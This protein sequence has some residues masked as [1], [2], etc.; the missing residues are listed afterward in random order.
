MNEAEQLEKRLGEI[1]T[2]I[3]RLEEALSSPAWELLVNYADEQIRMRDQGVVQ[4]ALSLE[5]VLRQNNLKSEAAGMRLLISLIPNHL[6][7]LRSQRKTWQIHQE[8]LNGRRDEP[9]PARDDPEL[10][11][12]AFLRSDEFQ[13]GV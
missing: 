7:E 11:F 9:A 2:E 12:D 1:D 8:N 10:D 3:L 4:P 6:R 13:P 5:D